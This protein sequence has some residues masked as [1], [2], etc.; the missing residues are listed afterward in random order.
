MR[1]I[2]TWKRPV[3]A[4]IA[5][6]VGA[7]LVVTWDLYL[8]PKLTETTVVVAAQTIHTNT[9]ITKS[10]LTTETILRTNEIP[11][12][13]NDSYE[14]IGKVATVEIG[15]GL[16][17]ASFMISQNDLIP[18]ETHQTYIIPLSWIYAIP[19]TV[20]RGDHITLYLVPNP[21]VPHFHVVNTKPFMVSVPVEYVLNSQG[22]EVTN[23]N[24][25]STA[26]SAENRQNSTSTINEIEVLLTQKQGQALIH[27]CSVNMMQLYITDQNS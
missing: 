5:T 4:V 18:N 23:L 15:Q 20:R 25:S 11:N 13:I 12:Q 21:Q 22:Q 8:H 24:P 14:L 6:L 17:F 10:D 19:N 26:N 9:P 1:G 3:I 16:P 7:A 2:G 27:A